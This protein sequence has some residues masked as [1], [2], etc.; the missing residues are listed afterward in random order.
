MV[1]DVDTQRPVFMPIEIEVEVNG[2]GAQQQEHQNHGGEGAITPLQPSP[3]PFRTEVLSL[4]APCLVSCEVSSVVRLTVNSPRYF[5]LT[6][7]PREHPEHMAALRSFKILVKRKL[8]YVALF[9]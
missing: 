2:T 6:L 4:V 8:G 7:R 9:I 1:V 5:P 3:S